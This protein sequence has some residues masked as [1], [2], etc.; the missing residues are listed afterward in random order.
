MFKNM[1]KRSW[2]S[3]IRKPSRSVIL[4]LI[5]FVMANLMLATIAIKKSVAKTTDYAK[6]KLS[7]TVYLQADMSAMQKE[8]QNRRSNAP[9]STSG[10]AAA[11][12]RFTMPEISES[13]VLG[14][15]ESQ[16]VNG[17]T[18]SV[19]ASANAASFTVVETEQNQR[20]REM[21]EQI[22]S[23][24]SGNAMGRPSFQFDGAMSRGDT[25]I[26]GINNFAYASGVEDGS[27]TLLDGAAFSAENEA[28]ISNEL[29]VDNELDLDDTITIEKIAE[30]ES[31]AVEITLK[32]VGIY[33]ATSENF[34]YNTLYTD[35]DTARQLTEVEGVE[36][37]RFYLESASDKEAFLAEMA[38]KYPE[39]ADNGLKLDIDDQ[40]Y[41][42]MVGPIENVGKFATTMMWVV[43]IAA[44]AIIT[45]M[46]VINVKD[47]RYE[48]GVLLS[49]GATR[50]TIVGQIFVE[51]A[52][53]GT[54]AFM[55]ATMTGNLVASKMGDALLQNQIAGEESTSTE[56]QGQFGGPGSMGGGMMPR[57]DQQASNV[58]Q[59]EEINVSAGASEY[60]VL[61]GVGYLI[62]L[63]AMVVP[64]V[65]IL[66]VS[67]KTILSGKE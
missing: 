63:L 4:V 41:Q 37:V 65:N 10:T 44:V 13:L 9:S 38:A 33:Q 19:N 22:E 35:I 51:L 61:F 29:A 56:A 17:Y 59:I 23:Q 60:A 39:I 2:L 28:I 21:Q 26:V 46:V 27:L 58:E 30:E 6:D 53:V 18:Y 49:L 11:P 20:E 67:P 57:P 50:A 45:L 16:Y 3:T 66:R 36:N 5:L 31:E 25:T 8:M 14:I 12:A 52:I 1:F 54:L 55:L 40:A 32:I 24:S 64:S 15:A 47:R 7:G 62:L 43:V 42:T 34:N 48:M